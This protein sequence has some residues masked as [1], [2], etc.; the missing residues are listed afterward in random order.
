MCLAWPPCDAAP[1][2]TARETHLATITSAFAPHTPS[3]G[4]SSKGLILHGPCMQFLQHRPVSPNPH[5]GCCASYRSHTVLM[6]DFSALLRAES[7]A[8]SIDFSIMTSAFIE[9]TSFIN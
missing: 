4:P 6:P 2:A 1:A 5:C 8:L 3:C 7:V 9:M